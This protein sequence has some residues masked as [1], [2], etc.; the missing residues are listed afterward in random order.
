[1]TAQEPN[2]R[3]GVAAVIS[4]REGRVVLG[5]RKGSIGAGKWGFP[6]GHL[7]FGETYFQCAEREAL[8]ETGLK[9]KAVKMMA[10][11]NDVYEEWQRH[12][13]TIFVECKREDPDQQPENLEPNKCDEWVWKGWSDIKAL[14]GSPSG[15][16]ELFLP[17]VNLINENPNIDA[18]MSK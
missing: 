9:V 15:T 8:E 4:D 16:K 17:I 3:V 1:M 2:V 11:T 5:R 13:I 10:V 18:M 14:Q 6:G 12:Y 7:E